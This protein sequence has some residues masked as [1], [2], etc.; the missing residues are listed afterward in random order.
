MVGF[1]WIWP[2]SQPPLYLH[3]AFRFRLWA[4]H[5]ICSPLTTYCSLTA[6]LAFLF[7]LFFFLLITACYVTLLLWFFFTAVVTT[8]VLYYPHP[9]SLTMR[10]EVRGVGYC[11]RSACL[12]ARLGWV[13]LDGGLLSKLNIRWCRLVWLLGL[14]GLV[15]FSFFFWCV[16]VRV[17]GVGR[18]GRRNSNGRVGSWSR[19]LSGRLVVWLSAMALGTLWRHCLVWDGV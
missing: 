15:W 13:G 3:G 10:R 6:N 1:S 5:G 12:L 7:V 19:W 8:F 9:T 2:P 11:P 18:C 14:D 16:Y 4:K 17:G